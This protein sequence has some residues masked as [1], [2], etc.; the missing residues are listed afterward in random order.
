MERR[1]ENDL[2]HLQYARM[3]LSIP[4]SS[5]GIC[6]S[7]FS[8]D[9]ISSIVGIVS[10][11]Y[12]PLASE[13]TTNLTGVRFCR[14]FL[15]FFPPVSPRSI[16]VCVPIHG[17]HQCSRQGY[18]ISMLPRPAQQD[19]RTPK[20]GTPVAVPAL[21]AFFETMSWCPRAASVDNTRIHAAIH[22]TGRRVSLWMASPF[23]PCP[24]CCI[25]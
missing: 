7:A 5:R 22:S 24:A 1:K 17:P 16:F 21:S 9:C 2:G 12:H 10:S 15:V 3:Q 25:S 4:R 20:N 6:V 11:P 19:A 8:C 18:S 23:F 13:R 14:S